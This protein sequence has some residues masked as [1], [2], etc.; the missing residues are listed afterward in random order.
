LAS[1][2]L[3]FQGDSITCGEALEKRLRWG[4]CGFATL[5]LR[6]IEIHRLSGLKG[7]TLRL[8]AE[9]CRKMEIDSHF[10]PETE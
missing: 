9:K 5:S 3:D 4:R 2:I 10:Y 1:E 6:L 8:F 7:E